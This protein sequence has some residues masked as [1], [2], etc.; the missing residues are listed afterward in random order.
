MR[1]RLDARNVVGHETP[2]RFDGRQQPMQVVSCA[3]CRGF[4]R[5]A[6]ARQVRASPALQ[7]ESG[8][9]A[10]REGAHA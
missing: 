9:A 10:H 1:D 3:S 4:V 8:C 7:R 2:I 5:P 6:D